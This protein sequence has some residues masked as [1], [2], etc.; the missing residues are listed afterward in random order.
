MLPEVRFGAGYNADAADEDSAGCRRRRTKVEDAV[1]VGV[2]V[3]FHHRLDLLPH[4]LESVVDQE[5]LVVDDSAE[6][7]LEGVDLPGEPR[8]LRTSGEVGFARAVNRGLEAAE[9]RGWTH[10][11]VLND[12][13]ALEPG[14]LQLLVEQ[15]GPRVGVVGPAV[16]SEED[17]ESAGI[18]FTWWGRVRL[19]RTLPESAERVPALSGACLLLRT[20]SRFEPGFAHGM[21]DI[22]LCRSLWRQG[23]AVVLEPRARCQHVG[24]ASVSRAGEDAQRHAVSGHLRLVEGGWR[25]PVVLGLAAAQALREGPALPRLRGVVRGWRDHRNA[26]A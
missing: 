22:A 12:D 15:C 19:R 23:L 11:L 4:A 21:E 1:R 14:S 18:D 3:P 8:V 7:L 26:R 24:G 13:A 10:A 25:T 2:I 9:A 16:L 20:G 17:V 6:G 5:I